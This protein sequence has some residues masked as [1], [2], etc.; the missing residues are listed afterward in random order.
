M[1]ALWLIAIA[2]WVF[3][4]VV[5]AEVVIWR[6]GLRYSKHVTDEHATDETV[7]SFQS[8]KPDTSWETCE[9]CRHF[10]LVMRNGD[11]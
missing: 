11:E 2:C 3:T 1:I 10:R 6:R 9:T 7:E 4:S 8:D 5:M